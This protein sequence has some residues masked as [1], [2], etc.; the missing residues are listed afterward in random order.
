MRNA[1]MA[2]LD[3]NVKMK[4]IRKLK[5]RVFSLNHDKVFPIVKLI[6]NHSF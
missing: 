5:F 6:T 3:V 2:N 1:W 4:E